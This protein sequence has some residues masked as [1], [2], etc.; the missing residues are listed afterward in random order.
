[1]GKFKKLLLLIF[2]LTVFSSCGFK[3][4]NYSELLNFTISEIKTSGEKRI[5]YK[6]KNKLKASSNSKERKLIS[7]NLYTT[8]VK[9]VKEKNIKNEITKYEIAVTVN[10]K[11]LEI[12]SNNKIEFTKKINGDY[13]V[14]NKYSQT[15]NNEKNLINVLTEELTKEILNEIIE[16]LSVN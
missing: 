11:I 2:I 5:N 1:M 16:K 9:S 7:L 15:I 8:K 13:S 10:V 4:V 6:I 14:S 3:A 12:N